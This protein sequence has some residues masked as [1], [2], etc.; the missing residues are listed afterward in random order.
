MTPKDRWLDLF[1][2]FLIGVGIWVY[3]LTKGTP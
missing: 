3:V 1:G 2:W